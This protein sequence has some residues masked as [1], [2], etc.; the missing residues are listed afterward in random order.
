M[1]RCCYIFMLIG[2][3]LL[4]ASPASARKTNQPV[5]V[6][7]FDLGAGGASLTRAS[8]DGRLYSNPA[9]L[10]YGGDVTRWVGGATSLMVNRDAVD[11][12]RN[13]AGGGGVSDE[14]VEEGAEGEGGRAN[15]FF[16]QLTKTPIRFGAQST[17][18]SYVYQNWGLSTFSSFEVDFRLFEFG[19]Y[20]LPEVRV[21]SENYYG[22]VFSLASRIPG[23]RWLSLGVTFKYINAAEDELNIPLADQE[24]IAATVAEYKDRYDKIAADPKEGANTGI[25]A[26]VGALAFFQGTYLDYSLALK[27]DD[28]GGTKFK[29]RN[30]FKPDSFKQVLSAGT[31]LTL[32]NE[33]SALHMSLDYRDIQN[34]YEEEMFKRVYAGTKLT[35]FGVLGFATGIYHGYPTYGAEI[36]LWAFRLTGSY[37]TKELGDHPGVDPRRMY[38]A[39]FS[40]GVSF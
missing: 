11:T 14:E 31:A 12:V 13:L 34:V 26:D 36:D 33:T 23:A 1:G 28:V 27:A 30:N 37:Y 5:Y 19:T 22:Q 2:A 38:M 8:R 20:G 32:H 29:V 40:A 6:D 39:T 25:G 24:T 16:E 7:P 18:N 9:L 15:D 4:C 17:V 35:F 3:V 21:I 10:P